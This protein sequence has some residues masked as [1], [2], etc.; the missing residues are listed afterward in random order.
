MAGSVAWESAADRLVRLVEDRH[1]VTELD[2]A[3]DRHLAEHAEI[4]VLALTQTAVA[5]DRPERVEVALAGVRVLRRH[6]APGVGLGDQQLGAAERDPPADPRILF[7][8]F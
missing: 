5:D 6:R 7:V 8:R 4:G 1:L 2:P 3:R